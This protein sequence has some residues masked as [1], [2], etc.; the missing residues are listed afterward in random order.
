MTFSLFDL[1]VIVGISQGLITGYLL[2]ASRQQQQRNRLLALILFT[3]ILL[4]CKILLHTLGL[5]NT[6]T[7]RYF[8]LAIDLAIQPLIYLFIQSSVTR[9][10]HFKRTSL[11][12]FLPFAA[13]MVH[14]I[15]VYAR[16]Q[17][18]T[19]M[20]VKYIIAQ[21]LWFNEVKSVED[22]L[23]VLSAWIY[24]V[25]SFR[26]IK[27]YRR[28]LNDNTADMTFPTYTWLRNVFV[29]FGVLMLILSVNLILDA[30]GFGLH[31][32]YHWQLFYL[33]LAVNIYYMGMQGYKQQALP[34]PEAKKETLMPANAYDEATLASAKERIMDA[35]TTGK[36][37]RDPEISLIKLSEKVGLSP[38]VVSHV[39]NNRN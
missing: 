25:L 32:F 21:D 37:Y 22:W 27:N 2:L 33:V 6:H 16:V 12:H 15:V 38:G 23:S 7:F 31:N 35:L 28:W 14:A 1:L 17:T 5:W 29:L 39:S 20:E 24:G 8:P 26:S 4:S 18:T 9:H 13:F 34:I 30:S 10:Y 3:F 36:V 11:L 19:V